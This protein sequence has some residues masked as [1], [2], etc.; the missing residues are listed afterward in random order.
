MMIAVDL[1]HQWCVCVHLNTP[2]PPFGEY[3]FNDERDDDDKEGTATYCRQKGGNIYSLFTSSL[4]HRVA[5]LIH[6]LRLLLILSQY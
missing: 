1:V 2:T 4:S 3:G 5:P 6:I